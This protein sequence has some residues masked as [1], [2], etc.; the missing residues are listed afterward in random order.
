MASR[1][2]LY[3]D[4]LGLL[5]ERKLSSLSEAREPR[6]VLDDF[7]SGVIKYCLERG[8]W[9]FAMRAIQ[10]DS[11]TSIVPTFG[12]SYAFTK[13]DDWVRT[14]IVAADEVFTLPGLLDFADEPGLW[15]ANVDPL[16]VKY[17]SDHASYGLDLSLWPETFTDYVTIRLA[18]QACYRITKSDA[19]VETLE[20]KEKQAKI[21]ALASDAMN[22]PPGRPQRGSW[23]RSR[24]LGFSN[25]NT[26]DRN[27]P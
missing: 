20:K 9:N 5:G 27:A 15:Y 24:Y 22:Q 6:R 21:V 7:Y 3:N 13:P 23:V 4:A 8:L 11:S 14:A 2:A 10:T 12:Y 18:G 1:L 16:Y 19:R 17:V 25:R 26:T